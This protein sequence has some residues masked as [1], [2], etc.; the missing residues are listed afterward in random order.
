MLWSRSIP[1]PADNEFS[2]IWSC[3][4]RETYRSLCSG[5]SRA[6]TLGRRKGTMIGQYRIVKSTKQE[7]KETIT[8]A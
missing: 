6:Y 1:G 4:G 7:R 3:G 5:F 8:K 2:S